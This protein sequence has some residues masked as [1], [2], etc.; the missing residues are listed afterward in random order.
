MLDRLEEM[1]GFSDK[2]RKPTK[3]MTT[4]ELIANIKHNISKK[5][6]K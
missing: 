3:D 5:D 2:P 6:K 4:E 1:F